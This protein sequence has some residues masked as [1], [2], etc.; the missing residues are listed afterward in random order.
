M[1]LVKDVSVVNPVSPTYLSYVQAR[2][3]LEKS[4]GLLAWFRLLYQ[5]CLLYVIV[6]GRA[7]LERRYLP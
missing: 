7:L 6:C 5:Q 1:A 3:V 2:R 4:T